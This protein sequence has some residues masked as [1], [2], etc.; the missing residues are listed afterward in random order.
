MDF[1]PGC[2]MISFSEFSAPITMTTSTPAESTKATSLSTATKATSPFPAARSLRKDSELGRTR[3]SAS[4][5]YLA[6]MPRDSAIITE[7]GRAR[8]RIRIFCGAACCAKE[9][10]GITIKTIA[11]IIQGRIIFGIRQK[12]GP[13][14]VLVA[15]ALLPVRFY[16]LRG[17]RER[18]LRWSFRSHK[19]HRS[20]AA[21]ACITCFPSKSLEVGTL[22][23]HHTCSIRSKAYSLMICIASLTFRE[24]RNYTAP[25]TKA[26]VGH[27]QSGEM[28]V[29]AVGVEPTRALR[30]CGFSYR[31]RLSPPRRIAPSRF[32]GFAVWTIPSPY[33]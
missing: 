17:F 29:R 30:P 3:N 22:R 25:G 12:N 9:G 33:S 5:P 21:D 26:A 11:A 4:I 23:I 10:T 32:G 6:R 16:G 14:R 28:L 20:A 13:E 19:P 18:K 7:S 8:Q 27:S 15:Q 2:A 1:V 31:L 24:S